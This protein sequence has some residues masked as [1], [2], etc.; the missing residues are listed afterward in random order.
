LC[1]CEVNLGFRIS[2][3]GFDCCCCRLLEVLAMVA[4]GFG[5]LIREL[6]RLL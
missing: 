4:K 1:A 2:F 5:I 3:N 6:V